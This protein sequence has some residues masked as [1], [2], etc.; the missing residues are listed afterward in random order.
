MEGKSALINIAAVMSGEIDKLILECSVPAEDGLISGVVFYDIKVKGIVK[1]MS[2]Y[3]NLTAEI[4]A[5][6]KTVCARCLKEIEGIHKTEIN[7]TLAAA[8]TLE[9]ECSDNVVDS[10]I[11]V[12]NNTLDLNLIVS[13]QILLDFP[14]RVL[15]DEKCR[16]L[17]PKCGI[18]LN[19]AIC[20]CDHKEIDPRLEV[21]KKL[22]E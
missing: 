16:G 5:P 17:C 7:K 8:G 1:N 20:E 21:L 13:E 10:Y 11:I 15:C 18:N 19:E 22:L 2:G 14:L 4:E 6:N 3:V 12:E 9:D